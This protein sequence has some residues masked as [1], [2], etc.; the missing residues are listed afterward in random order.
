[1]K[2]LK[3]FTRIFVSDLDTM[4]PF[5]EKL[6][7]SKA[8]LRFKYSEMNLELASVGDLLFIAG[9]PEALL[10]FRDTKLTFVVDSLD[11][12]LAYFKENGIECIRQPRKVPTGRNVTVRHP[13]GTIIEYVEHEQPLF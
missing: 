2:I 1:M 3:S 9:S 5:Y 8:Q 7:G 4:L 12:F 10:P 6:Y 11:D 13:D